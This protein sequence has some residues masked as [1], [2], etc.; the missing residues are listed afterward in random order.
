MSE[1]FFSKIKAFWKKKF[2]TYYDETRVDVL[3]L[4]FLGSLGETKLTLGVFEFDLIEN[5]TTRVLP[6][7]P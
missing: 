1:L 3:R 5:Q 2:N 7:S 6:P 4:G